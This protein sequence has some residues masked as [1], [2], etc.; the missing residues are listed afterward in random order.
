MKIILIGMPGSGKSSFATEISTFLGLEHIDTD[1]FIEKK[2]HLSINEIFKNSNENVFRKYEH[3][4]LKDI[5]KKEN[6]II[7]TGGGMPCYNN[8]IDLMNE[9]GIT[10][11]LKIS[12]DTLSQR[13]LNDNNERPLIKDK[14]DED[15]KI[16]LE[17]TLKNREQF[18]LKAKYTIDAEKSITEML[19]LLPFND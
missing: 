16:Y 18:Y 6:I 3:E 13:L 4:A 10:V 1:M 2:Y 14:S 19:R 9:S 11:Y 15:I 8:N 7:S 17:K 5:L 12:V